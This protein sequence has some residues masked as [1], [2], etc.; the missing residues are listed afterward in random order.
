MVLLEAAATGVPVV[1]SR[2]GGIPEG[3]VDGQTGLLAPERD[4]GALHVCMA[5]LL[6]QPDTRRR[7]GAAARALVE[8][9]FDIRRQG[10]R[11]EDLYDAVRSRP[12]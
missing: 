3:V 10:E 8:T 2:V 1:A 7:M 5:A 11:L 9:R 12:P 6:D 4:V